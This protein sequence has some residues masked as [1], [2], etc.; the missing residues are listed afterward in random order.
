MLSAVMA[1]AGTSAIQ[2]MQVF[3]MFEVNELGFG[4]CLFILLFWF[5]QFVYLFSVPTDLVLQQ[6]YHVIPWMLWWVPYYEF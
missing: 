6:H 1:A 5:L 2:A 4:I 3:N